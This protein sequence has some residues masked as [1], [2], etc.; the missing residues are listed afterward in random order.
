MWSH[1]VAIFPPLLLVNEIQNSFRLIAAARQANPIVCR[2]RWAER[3][4]TCP[5]KATVAVAA[6]G[7]RPIRAIWK[8]EMW[9][10]ANCLASTSHRGSSWQ[11]K[12]FQWLPAKAQSVYAPLNELM[13]KKILWGTK[14]SAPDHQISSLNQA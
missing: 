4:G 14:A 11:A 12:G 7:W 9:D 10:G 2:S 3:C 1:F 6:T 13:S 8:Y 5:P